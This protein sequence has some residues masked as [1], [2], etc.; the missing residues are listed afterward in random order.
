MEKLRSLLNAADMV[1]DIFS[2]LSTIHLR[3]K[4]VTEHFPHTQVTKVPFDASSCN[5]SVCYI[6][7]Q[8]LSR[9][10]LQSEDILECFMQPFSTSSDAL[11]EFTDVDFVNQHHQVTQ[12]ASHKT[13]FL[14]LYMDEL[15][16]TNTL[17]SAAR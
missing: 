7:V 12:D 5:D 8:K 3:K 15:E 17:G 11:S 4:Y 6:S 16:I 2:G 14:L 9:R 13:I 10:F 1:E